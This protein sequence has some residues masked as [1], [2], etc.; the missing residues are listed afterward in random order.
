MNEILFQ[1]FLMLYEWIH[2]HISL[3]F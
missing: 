3:V 1:F 2:D